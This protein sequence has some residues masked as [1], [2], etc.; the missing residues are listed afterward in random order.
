MKL[1]ID[2]PENKLALAKE[3][4]NSISFVKSVKEVAVNEV[5]NPSILKSIEDYE[6][7]KVLPTPMSLYELKKLMKA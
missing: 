4:F 1:I 7:K 5:T 6:A 2:I 3:F